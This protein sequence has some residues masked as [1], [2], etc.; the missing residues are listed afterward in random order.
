[1]NW[2]LIVVLMSGI[3]DSG[4]RYN[5][6]EECTSK[7]ITASFAETVK[8]LTDIGKDKKEKGLTEITIAKIVDEELE[9]Y[10]TIIKCV[11]SK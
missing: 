1:M 10:K 4:L 3:W 7:G 6:Y 8:H 9:N 11:P 2:A 5:S